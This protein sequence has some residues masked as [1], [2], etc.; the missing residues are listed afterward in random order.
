MNKLSLKTIGDLS[1]VYGLL[2][3]IFGSGLIFFSYIQRLFYNAN[4][5]PGNPN[6]DFKLCYAALSRLWLTYIPFMILIGGMFYLSGYFII[7]KNKN[8][9]RILLLSS[10]LNIIWYFLYAIAAAHDIVPLMANVFSPK[11]FMESYIMT[12]IVTCA[13]PFFILIY[14]PFVK[15]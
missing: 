14:L 1:K 7:K 9:K 3:M 11:S 2:G 6:I 8:G 15:E 12:G 5:F 10:I 13:Y 4:H